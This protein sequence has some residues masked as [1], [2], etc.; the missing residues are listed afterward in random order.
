MAWT[1]R[2]HGLSAEKGL[3]STWTKDEN[4]TWKLAMPDPPAAPRRSSVAGDTIFLNVA[5]ADKDSPPLT[6]WAVDC[7]KGE[8]LWKK[9]LG[10]GN[11]DDAQAEHVVAVAR[12][13]RQAACS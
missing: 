13:R 9:P 8:V 4:V 12:H 2:H 1:V 10:G 7:T 5:E 6:L 3:P 11:H